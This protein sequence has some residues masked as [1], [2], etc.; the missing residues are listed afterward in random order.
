MTVLITTAS[1]VDSTVE[2]IVTESALVFLERKGA[3]PVIADYEL[4]EDEPTRRDI[5]RIARDTKSDF[6]LFGT[7]NPAGGSAT[8]LVISF[9]LYLADPPIPVATFRGETEIDLSLD[10]SI[11]GFLEIL[12]DEAFA[13]LVEAE[14]ELLVGPSSADMDTTGGETATGSGISTDVSDSGGDGG[15]AGPDAVRLPGTLEVAVGYAPAFAVGEASGYYQFAHGAGGYLHFIV[16][17]RNGL[18]I[19]LNGSAVFVSATGIA[20]DG[21]LLIVPL[22]VSATIRSAPAPIGVYLTLGGGGALIQVSNPILGTYAKLVPYAT[23]GVGMKIALLDWLGL[24]AGVTFDAVF[25]GSLLLTSFV[26]SV[27]LY[28]GF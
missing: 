21:E 20:T 4:S 14:S 28:M 6:V 11:A 25:E 24:N 7:Y 9:S 2:R 17:K 1:T 26:P 19:G 10:R 12:L 15:G 22:A 8:T 16:G 5:T 23:G 13:Y 18:G 27:S 3:E